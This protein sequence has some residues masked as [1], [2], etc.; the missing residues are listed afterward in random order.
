MSTAVVSKLHSRRIISLEVLRIGRKRGINGKY[1]DKKRKK[2][3]NG[4]AI[5]DL[6]IN[7]LFQRLYHKKV[8]EDRKMLSEF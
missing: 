4:A 7:F 1:G 2:M 5:A 3:E 6:G 8:V